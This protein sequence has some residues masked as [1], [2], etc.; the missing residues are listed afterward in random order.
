MFRMCNIDMTY[1]SVVVDCAT[2]LLIKHMFC[3][4]FHF[5]MSYDTLVLCNYFWINF[6]FDR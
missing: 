2:A 3:I 4:R 5:H 6:A 1:H